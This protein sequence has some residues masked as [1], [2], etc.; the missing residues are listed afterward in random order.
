MERIYRRN[1]LTQQV[2]FKLQWILQ[3]SK[4]L[5]KRLIIMLAFDVLMGLVLLDYTGLEPVL[6]MRGWLTLYMK[7]L[8]H[9]TYASLEWIT[10]VPIGL[11]L[12]NELLTFIVNRFTYILQLWEEFYLFFSTQYLKTVLECLLYLRFLGLSIFLACF[13]DL[14]KF[15]NL[16]LISY[17][18]IVWRLLQLQT[19]GLVSLWRLFKGQKFNPL[20]ERVDSC[21]YDTNQLLLGTLL[22]T[23]LLF[24]YPTTL[25][26]YGVLLSLRCVQFVVQLLIRSLIVL[27]NKA[28]VL[29]LRHSMSNQLVIDISKASFQ[30]IGEGK[31]QV[32]CVIEGK[33]FNNLHELELLLK[34]TDTKDI[35]EPVPV[36]KEHK[37]VNWFDTSGF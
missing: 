28:S 24:L 22:F 20:R 13:H 31:V 10:S 16:Y 14:L 27:I 6:I 8:F 19:S 34:E 18:I 25:V 1:L 4:G 9:W 11:K 30:I 33:Y 37:L 26:L 35:S 23:I 36:A 29:I 7:T 12:N 15:L 21:N 5:R 3:K 32:L 17:Y 2:W